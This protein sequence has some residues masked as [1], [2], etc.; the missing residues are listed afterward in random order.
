MIIPRL[1]LIASHKKL[2]VY[3]HLLWVPADVDFVAL[4]SSNRRFLNEIVSPF[5]GISAD[6]IDDATI[7]IHETMILEIKAT[8]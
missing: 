5:M 4:F 2:T 1:A 7:A 8:I 3:S 6:E